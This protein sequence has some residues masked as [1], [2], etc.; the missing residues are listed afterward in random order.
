MQ[1]AFNFAEMG[2]LP[3]CLYDGDRHDFMYDPKKIEH[4]LIVAGYGKKMAENYYYPDSDGKQRPIPMQG[5]HFGARSL[6]GRQSPDVP[7]EPATVT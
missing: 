4:N 3:V 6:R 2:A 5:V 1:K 7:V